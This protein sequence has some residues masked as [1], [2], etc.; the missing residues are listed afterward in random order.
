MYYIKEEGRVCKEERKN[1]KNYPPPLQPRMK[2]LDFVGENV[3][4]D[5]WITRFTKV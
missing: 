4:V 2:F 1:W 3:V 5:H